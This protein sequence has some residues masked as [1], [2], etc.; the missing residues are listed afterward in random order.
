MIIG[1][2]WRSTGKEKADVSVRDLLDVE[3]LGSV[4]PLGS[5][6][7]EVKVWALA[8]AELRLHA[9]D[10]L[11]LS[12]GVFAFRSDATEPNEKVEP[13]VKQRVLADAFEERAGGTCCHNADN[14]LSRFARRP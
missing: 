9:P 12:V 8:F 7:P 1:D 2:R 4:G 10:H 6:G 14:A 5:T 13:L 3:C 11:K